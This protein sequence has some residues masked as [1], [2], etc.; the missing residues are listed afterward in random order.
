MNGLTKKQRRLKQEIDEIIGLIG[1]EFCNIGSVDK[2]WRTVHLERVKDHL[3]RSAVVTDYTLI[4]DH[5]DALL[6]QYFFG[7]RKSFIQLWKTKKFRNF[8]Y[9]ILQ[10]MFPLEKTEFARAFYRGIPNKIRNAIERINSLRN[11]LAHSFFPENLRKPPL[12]QSHSVYSMVGFR[13]YREDVGIV[14]GYFG[15]R[16]YR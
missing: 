9:Y 16:L 1:I 12:Y 7:K 6:C 10:K 13:L 11:S 14:N 5:L 3:V 15:R 4:N 2:E 8:N